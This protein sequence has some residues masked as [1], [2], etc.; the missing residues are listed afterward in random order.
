MSRW[1]ILL[2]S[3]VCLGSVI[4]VG[5]GQQV[6]SA[7]VNK[8]A[9]RVID[10]SSQLVSITCRVTVENTGKTPATN[11]LIAVDKAFKDY[12]SYIDV[13]LIKSDGSKLSLS[14][15]KVAGSSAG[16]NIDA[17]VGLWQAD[18]TS[19]PIKPGATID[20][21]MILVFTHKLEPFPTHISQSE[22]QLVLYNGNHYFYTP[23]KTTSQ[24]TR[25][26]LPATGNL[27]SYTKLKPSST[28]DKNI[29]LG[30]YENI[31]PFS[32]SNLQ[33]HVE[34]NSPF[35]AVSKL[36]RHIEVSHWS[37]VISI[38]ETIDMHHHGAILK[39]SFSRYEFQREQGN[40]VS[41]VKS[42]RTR[43]PSSAFD[44]Y[45]RDE[46]GNI[47]TSNI[48]KGSKSVIAELRPRFPM[49]GGWKTY[50]TLGYY[51]PTK[52]YLSYSG[53]KY[54]L[55]IPFV[56]HIFDNSIVDEAEVRIILPEGA[57][58]IKVRLPYTAT[59]EKDQVHKTYLD[60][61]GR[62]KIVL[63]KTNLVEL[64][65]KDIEIEYNYNRLYM[66]QEPLLI[67]A[68]LFLLCLTVSIFVRLDFSLVKSSAKDSSLKIGEIIESILSHHS[69]RN[70]LYQKY[71]QASTKVK[72][73]KDISAYHAT[74][75]QLNQELKQESTLIGD[76]LRKL[77]SE[78][79]VN[80]V[81]DKVNELQKLDKNLRDQ[82]TQQ[83]LLI[84]K[85]LS[86]RINKQLFI[87][88]DLNINKK[89]TEYL[90]KMAAMTSL[91]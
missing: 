35:L 23:Y 69:K 67:M 7:L 24:S 6:N 45:Y 66:L 49:F 41:A 22:K 2:I 65:I 27:E 40:A 89:K 68:A 8:K 10:I 36:E 5:T 91:L 20:L 38:E 52:D 47:S 55:R 39:G 46:I 11:Y 28:A 90:E 76:L 25:I 44:I 84:E 60:T 34:N 15:S 85:L 14:L 51:V 70:S 82:L 75:K 16:S 71:E 31:A 80:E 13:K 59:R 29:N 62:P 73:T 56:D 79:S 17:S 32:K 3:V 4:K 81:V 77:K 61:I 30:P 12:L 57:S 18:L 88:T 87:D 72:N 53:G 19:N 1:I 50:Y 86:N 21:D 9:D 42:F 26:K 43:L 33:V 37:G 63:R 83:S 74:I 54:L 58:D 48:R 64:H 78:S